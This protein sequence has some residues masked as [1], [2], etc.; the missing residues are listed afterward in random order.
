MC[1]HNFRCQHSGR[2]ITVLRSPSGSPWVTSQSA[3]GISHSAPTSSSFAS[4]LGPRRGF[5]CGGGEPLPR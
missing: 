4:E 2:D 1:Q 5:A 3:L